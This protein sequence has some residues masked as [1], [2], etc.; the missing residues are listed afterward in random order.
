MVVPSVSLSRTVYPRSAKGVNGKIGQ[1]LHN[2]GNKL[3]AR[4][5]ELATPGLPEKVAF[6]WLSLLTPPNQAFQRISIQNCEVGDAYNQAVRIILDNEA[7]ARMTWMLTV[8]TDNIPEPDALIQLLA[9]AERGNY[10]AIG[11]LYYQKGEGGGPMCYGK[12]GEMPK[13]YK[14]WIPPPNSV[15]D[16]NGIAMGFSLFKIDMLKRIPPPWFKTT[17]EWIPG[18]GEVSGT[19]DLFFCKKAGAMGFRFGVSSK[20]RVGHL[21]IR[22]GIVW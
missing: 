8:E 9:D 12:T 13:S 10:D 20:V 17:Q 2:L 6:S 16:V 22:T 14:P 7:L 1:V 18:S 4:C 3:G 11:A 19:Q 5:P 15:V 21:D